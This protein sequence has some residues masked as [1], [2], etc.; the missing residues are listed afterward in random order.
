MKSS[1]RPSASRGVPAAAAATADAA[2]AAAAP[3]P[4]PCPCV[5]C[6]PDGRKSVHAQHAHTKASESSACVRACVRVPGGLF[7]A[8]A[9]ARARQTLTRTVLE[10]IFNVRQ[11][12][13]Q[14]WRWL[15]S[16]RSRRHLVVVDGVSLHRVRHDG[17]GL[18]LCLSNRVR[19]R[20]CCSIGR[21]QL[22]VFVDF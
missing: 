7:S 4:S 8:T 14:R 12:V 13:F 3:S 5:C 18:G 9:R 21:H 6:P 15:L 11:A 19:L 22:R 10:P 20:L 2:S 16:R 1:S 17:I